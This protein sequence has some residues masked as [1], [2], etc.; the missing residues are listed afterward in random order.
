MEQ[1][2]LIPQ[3][4]IAHKRDGREFSAAQIRRV[5]E[6]IASGDF[7]D[8][9]VAALSMA[10]FLK[11][12]TFGERL[13]LTL[14][15]RDSGT[16]FAWDLNG[17]VLDKHSTGGIGDCVSLVLAPALAAC[18]AFVPMISARGLGHTGGTVDKL[19]A[20]PGYQTNVGSRMFRSVVSRVGCAIVGQ[21]GEI[22]PADGRLFGIRDETATV[23]S[24]ELITSSILSKKLAGGIE[25]LVLDVKVGSGAFCRDG[26]EAEALAGE[27]VRVARR[28]G[29]P[30]VA[31]LT[32]M[33]Q[34]LAPNAGNAL[35]VRS[36]L[37]VLTGSV[38]GMSRLQRL[39]ERLGGELLAIGS[40]ASSVADGENR[41]RESITSGSAAEIF[42]R[43]VC[44]LGGPADILEPKH[45]LLG[46]SPVRLPV[47]A[48]GSG[49]VGTI[50]CRRLGMVVVELGGGRRKAGDR[51]DHRV[52]LEDICETGSRIEE[53]DPLAW[54]HAR[55]RDDFDRLLPDVMASFEIEQERKSND[56]LIRGRVADGRS[57]P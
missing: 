14:A 4:L 42:G 15:M 48:P 40:I 32:G 31:M 29:C 24:I 39:T 22:A 7:S 6:G 41:I 21:T 11:G 28:A 33:D 25:G 54:I 2:P 38:K 36:T 57:E 18:G 20:I 49:H 35:E 43:M 10:I 30:T 45:D 27:L 9:Q 37:D 1:R 46:G 44:E 34:P 23:Q 13:E 12:M 50:D 17:P 53:G 55:A 8:A 3:D 51:I 5:V 16:V 26:S 47:P 19:E 52:G 56:Q